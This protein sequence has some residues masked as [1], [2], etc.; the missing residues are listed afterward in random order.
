V[1]VERVR[2]SDLRRV[3]RREPATIVERAIEFSR[4]PFLEVFET[5]RRLH[6]RLDAGS[7]WLI[8]DFGERPPPLAEVTMALALGRVGRRAWL[9]GGALVVVV[10]EP[11]AEL[12]LRRGDRAAAKLNMVRTRALAYARIAALQAARQTPS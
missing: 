3:V 5:G 12:A 4:N 11:D 1:S 9:A 2:E 8:V 6:V 7:R 10:P